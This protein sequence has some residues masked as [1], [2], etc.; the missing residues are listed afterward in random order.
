MPNVN[1]RVSIG[2][3][4][5]QDSI[6]VSDVLK[7]DPS[8]L[9]L[10]WTWTMSQGMKQPVEDGQDKETDSSLALPRGHNPSISSFSTMR[11]VTELHNGK[12]TD[13]L[14]NKK[15]N[16]NGTCLAARGN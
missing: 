9:I 8:L 1:T 12:I 16:S 13:G 7:P 15:I 3:R 14:L 2:T 10:R 4:G 11:P 6:K 5:R